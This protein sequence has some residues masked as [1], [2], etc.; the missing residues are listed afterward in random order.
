MNMWEIQKK[1]TLYILSWKFHYN[2][3]KT[4]IGICLFKNDQRHIQKCI[5]FFITLVVLLE[6]VKLIALFSAFVRLESSSRQE[7]FRSSTVSEVMNSVS[8]PVQ[9]M[10]LSW[11]SPFLTLKTSI[12]ITNGLG[13]GPS[14]TAGRLNFNLEIMLI[15]LAIHRQKELTALPLHDRAA[16]S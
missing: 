11:L 13:V 4:L 15:R 12:Q 6:W 3:I 7:E 2:V 9:A 5:C 10:Q 1:K 8:F 16:S 14:I